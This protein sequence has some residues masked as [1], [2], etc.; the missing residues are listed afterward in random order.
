MDESIRDVIEYVEAARAALLEVAGSLSPEQLAAR[1]EPDAWSP[2][3]ILEHLAVVERRVAAGVGARVGAARVEG[4][5]GA[6][7]VRTLE[8]RMYRFRSAVGRRLTAP[9]EIAPSGGLAR[10][11]LVERLGRSRAALFS[12]LAAADGLPLDELTFPH[13]V[14]GDLSVPDWVL[15]VGAHERRHLAQIERALARGASA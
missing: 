9:P 2:A 8:E 4:L 6:P 14:F 15:F 12:A 3:E 1:P 10:E 5:S 11:E 13:P 7:S